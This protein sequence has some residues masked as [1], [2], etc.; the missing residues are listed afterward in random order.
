MAKMGT[1]GRMQRWLA[2]YHWANSPPIGLA[3]GEELGVEEGSG[4][5]RDAMLR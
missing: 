5:L 1:H 2:V 4:A 3:N